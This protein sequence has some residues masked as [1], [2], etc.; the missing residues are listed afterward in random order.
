[1]S[2]AF[3]AVVLVLALVAGGCLVGPDYQRPE[4]ET[5]A[6]WRL[7]ARQSRQ[8]AQAGWWR[9]FGDPVLEEL[10]DVALRE[11]LDL[12]IAA[13]RVE[14]YAALY[15]VARADLFPQVGASLDAQRQR[16]SEQG[17]NPLPSGYQV[18]ANSL[19]GALN[20]SWEVDLWGRVR[21]ANQAARA[22]LLASEEGR[23]GAV[24]SLVAAVAG[25]YVNLRSLDHQLEIARRTAELRRDSYR[26]F[27]LRLEGGLISEVELNQVKSEYEQALAT[28]PQLQKAVVQAENALSLLLGRNPGAVN[29]GKNLADLALPAIPAGLPSDLLERRPDIRQAEQTLVAANAQIG[30]AKAAYFPAI[31]LTGLFGTASAELSDLFAGPAKTWQYGASLSLPIFTAGRLAGQVQAAEAV[32][33]QALLSY[34]KAIQTAF[35]EVDDAL[36]DQALTREQ[37]AAQERQVRALKDYAR[38]ARLRYDNGYTSYLEVL[39]AERTLFSAELAYTQTQGG[40]FQAMISLYK[41]MGGGWEETPPPLPAH[42]AAGGQSG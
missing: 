36:V 24:L 6:A 3:A 12:L 41:A 37:L 40:L 38:F 7:D 15:G 23:R 35:R 13:A 10:I 25:A 8:I 4:V 28:I 33:K 34:Q 2:R 27:T 19:Q 29:R 22:N 5:P 9:Q 31:S 39:D 18:T 26:L 17:A 1:M 30:V 32:R 11:N 20:A 16:V 42:K 14:Q 21:R